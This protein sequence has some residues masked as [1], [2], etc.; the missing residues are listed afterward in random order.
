MKHIF[1][2]ILFFVGFQGSDVKQKS[3]FQDGEWFKFEMS[4]SGLVTA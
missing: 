1:T 2:I 4:Y 3:A